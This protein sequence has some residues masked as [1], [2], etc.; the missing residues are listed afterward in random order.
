MQ[1]MDIIN[2]K[3]AMANAYNKQFIDLSCSVC[4][5]QYRTTFFWYHNK[6]N[7]V[8]VEI[9]KH[10]S[11]SIIYDIRIVYRIFQGK[12]RLFW[13]AYTKTFQRAWKN[14]NSF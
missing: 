1:A 6:L 7:N 13:V 10:T 4:T 9:K 12:T 14:S 5:V 11:F 8:R 2:N 3:I